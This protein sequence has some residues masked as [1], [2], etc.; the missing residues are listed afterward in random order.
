MNEQ[1]IDQL[2]QGLKKSGRSWTPRRMLAFM[3]CLSIVFS[4]IMTSVMGMRWDIGQALERFDYRLEFFLLLGLGLWAYVVAARTAIPGLGRTP[5]RVFWALPGLMA[6]LS[7]L[8]LQHSAHAAGK[9]WRDGWHCFVLISAN[10]L[11]PIVAALVM[12][13]KQAAPTHPLFTMSFVL[14]GSLGIAVATQHVICKVDETWHLITWHL[15]VFPVALLLAR[16]LGRRV[17]GW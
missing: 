5:Q 13:R 9:E 1:L 3:L 17:L 6:L 8:F 12:L 16:V 14:L 11:I 7:G 4:V 2:A 10:A 15:G